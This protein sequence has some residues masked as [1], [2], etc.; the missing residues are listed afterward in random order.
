MADLA[1]AVEP[2]R[3]L[4]LQPRIC[5]FKPLGHPLRIARLFD[6]RLGIPLAPPG[7]EEITAINMQR[8][9]Q[10]RQRIGHRMNDVLAQRHDVL[11]RQRLCSR[12]FDAFL[13]VRQA[14]PENVVF[15][16]RVDPDDRPHAVIVRQE[17]HPRR[18]DDIQD[19]EVVCAVQRLDLPLSWFPKSGQN[20]PGQRHGTRYHFAD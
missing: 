10:S 13:A 19:R 16:T 1:A 11:F 5:F 14:S 20:G 2:L 18:P 3:L 17:V 7:R 6:E 8:P 12:C 15:A 9:R 4:P